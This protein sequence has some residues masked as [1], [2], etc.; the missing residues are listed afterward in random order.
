[1]KRCESCHSYVR[2]VM[3]R[4]S[5]WPILQPALAPPVNCSS[6]RIITSPAYYIAKA[7]LWKL[8]ACR[9]PMAHQPSKT[10]RKSTRL[11][12]SHV[13]ISYAVFCF[14]EKEKKNIQLSTYNIYDD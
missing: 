13:A 10:D 14:E 6:S 5:F 9:L 12:S 11:N 1:M 4:L 7:F 3:F 2:T 8:W